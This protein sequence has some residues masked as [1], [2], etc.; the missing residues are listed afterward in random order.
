MKITLRYLILLLH[1][2]MVCARAFYF[3]FHLPCVVTKSICKWFLGTKRT[4][5]EDTNANSVLDEDV[6]IVAL[7]VVYLLHRAKTMLET[8]FCCCRE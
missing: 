4:V 3:Y 7:C 2:Q 1:R 6:T 8:F 5:D